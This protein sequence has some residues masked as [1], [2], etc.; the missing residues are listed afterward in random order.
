M[1]EKLNVKPAERGTRTFDVLV[2]FFKSDFAFVIGIVLLIICGL[3]LFSVLLPVIGWVG[4][5]VENQLP[6]I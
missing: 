6:D 4:E 5:W 1:S 3:F 2:R